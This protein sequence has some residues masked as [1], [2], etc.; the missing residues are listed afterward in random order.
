MFNSE[1]ILFEDNHIIII[2][3]VSGQ[4]VQPDKEKN[5]SLEEDIKAYIKKETQNPV[6]FSW[7][8]FTVL[9]DL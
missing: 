8:L 3:K 4:L 5:D 9:I 1:N 7:A 6:M 2:N